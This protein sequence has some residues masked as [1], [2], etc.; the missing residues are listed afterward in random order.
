[1]T[2]YACRYRV[3]GV[4]CGTRDVNFDSFQSRFSSESCYA[5]KYQTYLSWESSHEIRKHNT[6]EMKHIII[7]NNRERQ[8]CLTIMHI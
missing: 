4:A 7:V 3:T 6:T 1:M 8:F 5:T 2:L